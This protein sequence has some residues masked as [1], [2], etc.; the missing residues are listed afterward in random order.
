MNTKCLQLLLIVYLAALTCRADTPTNDWTSSLQ[1]ALKGVN[2]LRVRSGGT[3]CRNCEEEKLLID[4]RNAS[5]I[6]SFIHK[7]QINPTNSGGYCMCCGD[8]TFE[9]YQDKALV[10]SL[11]LHHRSSL[12]WPT[13]KW[14]GDGRLTKDSAVFISKWLADRGVTN[15]ADATAYKLLNTQDFADSIKR[16]NHT[17]PVSLRPFWNFEDRRDSPILKEMQIALQKEIGDEQKQ[18]LAL[19][20]WYGSGAGPWVGYPS[21]ESVAEDLLLGY[22]TSLII[23]TIRKAKLTEAQ[24]EGAARL[25]ASGHF[26]Q[27]NPQDLQ[28]IPADLK[29]RLLEHCQKSGDIDKKDKAE[30]A[31]EP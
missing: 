12:R 7:I 6:N 29:Q 27:R 14:Q 13:G 11:G 22:R 25:F 24:T 21:Y 10:L 28:M 2:R 3:C 18:I 8:P 19:L 31:F 30:T 23:V 15:L 26:A 1:E 17:M 5:E 9:F 16:W 4:V 20:E